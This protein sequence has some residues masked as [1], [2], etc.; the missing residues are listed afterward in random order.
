[1]SA[2]IDKSK[3]ETQDKKDL[4]QAVDTGSNNCVFIK[5]AIEN[6]QELAVTIV[7]DLFETKEKRTKFSNRLIPVDKVCRANIDEIVNNSG[8]LFDLHFLKEPF[9]FAIIFNRR[10][11]HDIIRDDVIK[12]LADLVTQKN[13][14]N[15]VD[16]K[17]PQKTILIEIIKGLCLISIIPDYLKLKKYNLNELHSPS[18]SSNNESQ[19]KKLEHTESEENNSKTVVDDVKSD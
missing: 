6:Y 11:N 12:Q 8:A 14:R 17:N 10:C 15:K 13:I 19:P 5:T 4:F 9:T 7:R 3:Q 18:S 2:A 16:L 1:M